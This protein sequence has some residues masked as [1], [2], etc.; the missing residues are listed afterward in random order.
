MTGVEQRREDRWIAVVIFLFLMAAYH[1][2]IDLSF[3]ADSTSN[4]LLAAS[5]LVDGDL[6]FS[7][8]EA[9]LLFHWRVKPA[10]GGDEGKPVDLTLWDDEL[11]R[12]RGEGTL[13][14]QGPRYLIVPVVGD[15]GA[16]ASTFNPGAALAALP[17]FALIRAWLGDPRDVPAALWFGGKF[18]AASYVA[19][20]AALVFL[21]ARGYTGRGRAAAL[22]LAYGLGTSVWSTSSQGLWQHGPTEFFLMLG[23]YWLS[24]PGGTPWR[25]TGTGASLGMATLCRPTMV[26][27]V[28][29]AAADWLL[30]SRRAFVAY[31]LAG[32]PMASF[33]LVYNHLFFGSPF[34]FGESLVLSHALDKTGGTDIFP[35]PLWVGGL[36][37]LV[38]PSRGLFVFSPFLLWAL[39][40][41]YATWRRAELARLRCLAIGVLGVWLVQFGY[42]DYWGGWCYGN[43]TLVDTTP[44]LTVLIA[45]VLGT[46]REQPARTALFGLAVGWSIAAQ[47]LGAFAYDLGGWNGRHAVEIRRPAAEPVVTFDL[48]EAARLAAR[49]GA[50]RRDLSLDIDKPAQRGRL[51]SLADSQLVYYLTHWAESRRAR[52]G[53]STMFARDHDR[54]LADNHARIGRIFLDAGDWHAAARSFEWA[55]K[56]DPANELYRADLQRAQARQPGEAP[57]SPASAPA[58]P[59]PLTPDSPPP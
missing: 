28:L 54:Q 27:F 49:P 47:A 48:E 23:V 56:L 33:L 7:P 45:P 12:L 42:F 17:F 44:I 58:Q 34:S 15:G 31:V 25:A 13:E 19:A 51:W 30:R 32:L 1:A 10:D 55:I 38:S 37:S 35:T 26:F 36:V 57:P 16:F 50:T 29:A 43:R 18:I 4:V 40:G 20:S 21:M 3:A 41:A 5:I 24:R 14:V 11:G 52:A 46:F 8:D 22:A 6:T 39:P 2:N 9:P 59:E 53:L